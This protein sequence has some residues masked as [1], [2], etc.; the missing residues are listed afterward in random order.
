M[1][2]LLKNKA[3]DRTESFE[4]LANRCPA[5]TFTLWSTL[6]KTTA[7]EKECGTKKGIF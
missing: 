7:I 6:L 3:K 1:L 4:N 5:P 2:L